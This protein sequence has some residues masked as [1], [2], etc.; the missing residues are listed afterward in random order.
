[1]AMENIGGPGEGP[2]TPKESSTEATKK[3]G[4]WEVTI[5]GLFCI[6][7]TTSIF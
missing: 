3:E 1:M 2:C 7:V 5:D 6:K 4:Y